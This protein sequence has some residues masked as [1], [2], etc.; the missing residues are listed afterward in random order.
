MRHRY[1][2]EALHWLRQQR[3]DQQAALVS[4]SAARTERARREQARLE[5]ERQ[6]SERLLSETA[7]A[8]RSRLDEGELR[9]ADLQLG[10]D[11]RKGAEAQVRAMAEQEQKAREARAA[12]AATEAAERRAL[13]AA[14]NQAKMIDTHRGA[15]RAERDAARERVDEE[16]AT[17]QWTASRF[18]PRRT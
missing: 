14:S 9:A 6:N 4:E 13:G 16:A 5:L 7:Q 18:P 15:F 3:V 1:P 11:W 10:G 12:Q 17:E 2:F 8:E